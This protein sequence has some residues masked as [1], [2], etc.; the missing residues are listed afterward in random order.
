MDSEETVNALVYNFPIQIICLRK[1]G[2]NT[3]DSLLE[4]V[5]EEMTVDEWG[6]CL[7]QII[8]ILIT[9]QKLFDF[10]HNDLHTNNIMYQ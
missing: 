3:L 1:N 6:S 2:F 5:E 7:F 9:Y 10:T 8:M 4:N